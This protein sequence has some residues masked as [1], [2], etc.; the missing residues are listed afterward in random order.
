[1]RMAIA[2]LFAATFTISVSAQEFLA[3]PGTPAAAFPNPDRPVANIVSPIWHDEKERDDAEEPR[4]LV[5]L[6]GIKAGMTVLA[7][8]D[9]IVTLKNSGPRDQ[10][11]GRAVKALEA[12]KR[13]LATP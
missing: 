12:W 7:S 4:Q 10:R 1:M 2:T 9:L 5:R 13:E 11:I 6:L 3:G 8:L